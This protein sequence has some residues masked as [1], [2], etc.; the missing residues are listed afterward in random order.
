MLLRRDADAH[1]NMRLRRIC[2][3]I[4]YCILDIRKMLGGLFVKDCE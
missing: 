4:L 3:V 1:P 2:I